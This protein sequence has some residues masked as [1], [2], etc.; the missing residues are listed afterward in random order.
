MYILGKH[1]GMKN[2]LHQKQH[3][4][5]GVNQESF[6]PAQV[7][8]ISAYIYIVKDKSV[9]KIHNHS[10][11][12]TRQEELGNEA[13]FP[14]VIGTVHCSICSQLNNTHDHIAIYISL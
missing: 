12:C 4:N 14:K 10:I 3:R 8:L 13:R 6:G 1:T 9:I 2:E 7:A 11:I 5:S